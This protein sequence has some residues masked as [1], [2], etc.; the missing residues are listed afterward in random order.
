MQPRGLSRKSI[1]ISALYP[2]TLLTGHGAGLLPGNSSKAMRRQLTMRMQVVMH[3][4][5]ALRVITKP[6][7]SAL[8]AGLTH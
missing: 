8:L 1:G 6:I 4:S 7:G 3:S 5:L 2:L